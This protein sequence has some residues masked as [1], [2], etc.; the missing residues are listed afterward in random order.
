MQMAPAGICLHAASSSLGS[1]LP[2]RTPD[3]PAQINCRCKSLA[4]KSDAVA[5][6]QS[7]CKTMMQVSPLLIQGSILHSA[8][9]AA[10]HV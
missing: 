9:W 5:R 2:P 6:D 1:S 10:W 4:F 3:C 7:R 8:R